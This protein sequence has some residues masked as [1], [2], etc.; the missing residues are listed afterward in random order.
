MLSDG[1]AKL[2]EKNRNYLE[3]AKENSGRYEVENAESI[4]STQIMEQ[5]I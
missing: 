5:F 1:R 2:F 3:E 4:L